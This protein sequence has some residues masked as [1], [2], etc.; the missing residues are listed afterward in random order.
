MSFY[1]QLVGRSRTIFYAS[2]KISIPGGVSTM[3]EQK[4]EFRTREDATMFSERYLCLGY[5]I[6]I[7][8]TNN[9]EEELL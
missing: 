9:E 8:E 3:Y 6:L 1:I 2:S 7:R 5:V 4:K